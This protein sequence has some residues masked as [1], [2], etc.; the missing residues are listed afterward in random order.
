MAIRLTLSCPL[1]AASLAGAVA[2]MLAGSAGA[3]GTLSALQT[4][5]DRIARRARP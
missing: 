5:V 3:Q 1:R 2:L 4:D